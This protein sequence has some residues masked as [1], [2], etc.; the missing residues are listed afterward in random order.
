M[1]LK[2]MLGICGLFA[3]AALLIT[4]GSSGY[5]VAIDVSLAI[6]IV[7]SVPLALKCLSFQRTQRLAR[8]LRDRLV[9]AHGLCAVCAVIALALTEAGP[10]R[11]LVGLPWFL[12]TVGVA[13]C[14]ALCSFQYRGP[15]RIEER[16][17]DIA[18]IYLAVGGVWFVASLGGFSLMGFH[19]PIVRLTAVHFHVAS[20]CLVLV[21]A[22]LAYRVIQSG[23][24]SPRVMRWALAVHV[25]SPAIVAVGITF[26]RVLEVVGA[27]SLVL[28]WL[29]IIVMTVRAGVLLSLPR[30]ARFFLS[31]SFLCLG[32]TLLLA[33]SYSA[34]RI[35]VIPEMALTHGLINAFVVIPAALLALMWAP[36]AVVDGDDVRLLKER[37]SSIPVSGSGW[38]LFPLIHERYEVPLGKLSPEAFERIGDLISS[39]RVYAPELLESAA[40]FR[41]E[42]REARVGD[43]IY[44]RLHLLDWQGEPLVTLPSLVEV[45]RAEFSETRKELGYVTTRFHV[46]VGWWRVVVERLPSGEGILTIEAASRP[47]GILMLTLPLFRILQS[48]ARKSAI[49]RISAVARNAGC[50]Q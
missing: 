11:T 14:G 10:V 22:M 6:T 9:Q 4:R 20:F 32:V 17:T 41:E 33:L 5:Q 19:E 37:C 38:R 50:T 2:S 12:L 24:A 45:D 21:S 29:S 46:G 48:R 31:T 42:R 16:G 25:V 35:P 18:C 44:Q 47:R 13:A 8:R 7:V 30:R 40:M 34:L 27:L 49:E 26:S 39:Y 28:S 1:I 15:W 23:R 43:R 36:V 3:F